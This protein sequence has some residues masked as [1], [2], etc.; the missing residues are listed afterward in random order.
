MD[1]V[2]GNY[3]STTVAILYGKAGDG[4]DPPVFYETGRFPGYVACRDFDDDGDIDIFTANYYEDSVSI[5]INEGSRI[6]ATPLKYYVGSGPSFINADDID[7]DGD[8][9]LVVPCQDG[10]WLHVME[11][12]GDGTFANLA[13]LAGSMPHR[14]AVFDINNDGDLDIVVSNRMS[15]DVMLFTNGGNGVFTKRGSY[16]VGPGPQ[17]LCAGFFDGDEYPDLAVANCG[18]GNV[19]IL[20]SRVELFP[21]GIEDFTG[22]RE[23][24]NDFSLE[25]NYPNPFN[26]STIIS[27]S[28]LRRLHVTVSV[29]DILGRRVITLVDES[30][31]EGSYH[32]R[33]DGRDAK[34]REIATGV[35]LYQ[36]RTEDFTETKKMTL[37]K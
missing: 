10:G 12:R 26:P 20:F 27:Y 36:I 1:L 13:Y 31:G 9:D 29:Y 33:W 24:P 35:Y 7:G 11:N 16:A 5:L 19:M 28:L 4:F 21:V 2:V 30:Q 34:G 22:V 32:V 15:N 6:F 23:L 8:I 25:Q 37:L 17:N 14:S 18:T 3:D